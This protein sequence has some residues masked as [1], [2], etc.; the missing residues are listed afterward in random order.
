MNGEI[1][2]LRVLVSHLLLIIV[3]SATAAFGQ[4]TGDRLEAFSGD[5]CTGELLQDN[6]E[7]FWTEAEQWAW[8]QICNGRAAN[9]A[10]AGPAGYD[11]QRCNPSEIEGVVPAHRT[12]SAAFMRFI[13]THPRWLAGQSKPNIFIQCAK[14][15]G[16]LDLDNTKILP[17]LTFRECHFPNGASLQDAVFEHNLMIIASTF[18]HPSFPGLRG[19]DGLSAAGV[20]VGGVLALSAGSRLQHV[21]LT[22]ASIGDTLELSGSVFEGLFAAE[23]LSVGGN[24]TLRDRATFG[25]IYLDDAKIQGSLLA[26]DANFKGSFTANRILIDRILAFR[27]VQARDVSLGDASVQLITFDDTKIGELWA[28]RIEVASS[29]LLRGDD[30]TYGSVDIQEANVF[31][32]MAF[33]GPTFNSAITADRLAVGDDLFFSSGSVFSDVY[34]TGAEIAGTIHLGGG[35]FDG[36]FDFSSSSAAE[37]RLFSP[38]MAD[39]L[40]RPNDGP[41]WNDTARLLLRNAKVAALQSRAA[42]WQQAD[43]E[44]VPTDLTGFTYDRLSGYRGDAAGSLYNEPAGV[45]EDWL[46]GT[47]GDRDQYDPQPYEQLAAVLDMSGMTIK[48]DAIRYAKFRHRDRIQQHEWSALGPIRFMSRWVIGYGVYPERAAWWFTALVGV[49]FT[50]AFASQAVH[51]RPI[52]R[53]F[54]YSIESALPLVELSEQHKEISHGRWWVEFYFNFQKVLGFVLATFL[55]SALTLLG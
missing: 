29:M 38:G 53:K 34:L 13:L 11:N 48:A 32:Q 52:Y 39:A 55:V 50:V 42:S 6:A 54:W 4:S 16:R 9:M 3:L 28:Q 51:L 30:S 43:G 35:T 15:V 17:N 49:G 27:S 24:L 45:L 5:T 1:K 36:W 21:D 31:G 44:W 25:D 18:R 7:F 41:I 12:L 46:V 26:E 2:S 47:K 33:S 10:L 22:R 19:I 37:L 8:Y 20:S 23:R 40:G 14:L